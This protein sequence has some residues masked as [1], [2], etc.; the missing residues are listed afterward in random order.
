MPTA[1]VCIRLKCGA[2][3]EN[4]AARLSPLRLCA[5]RV[6]CNPVSNEYCA[7]CTSEMT[8]RDNENDKRKIS[9]RSQNPVLDENEAAAAAT[10]ALR[11]ICSLSGRRRIRPFRLLRRVQIS[12]GDPKMIMW[13]LPSLSL[14]QLQAAYNEPLFCT[15]YIVKSANLDFSSFRNEILTASECLRGC[16]HKRRRAQYR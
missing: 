15:W 16:R 14:F 1:I 12:G 4:R 11:Y 5:R 13:F 9:L 8:L 7:S 6:S 10:P 3:C 2:F